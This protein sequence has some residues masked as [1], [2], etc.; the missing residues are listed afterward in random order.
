MKAVVFHAIG[1]IRLEDVP[2]P[3]LQDPTDV[4]RSGRGLCWHA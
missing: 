1:D 2:E 4:S 3:E